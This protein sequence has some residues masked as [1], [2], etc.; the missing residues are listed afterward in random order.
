MQ[1]TCEWKTPNACMVHACSTHMGVFH[2][3]YW[4]YTDRDVKA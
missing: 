4:R 3:P 2:Y 1:C